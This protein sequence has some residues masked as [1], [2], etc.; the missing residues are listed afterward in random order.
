[1]EPSR[2]RILIMDDEMLVREMLADM[3]DYLGYDAECVTDGEQALRRYREELDGA[4]PFEVVILDL[5]IPGGMGGLEALDGLKQL[6][7]DVRTIVSSGA[8]DS[9]DPQERGFSAA[10][11]KPF[12]MNDLQ[13]A[14]RQLIAGG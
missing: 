8:T 10:I 5:T 6:D 11:A 7:A 1:M 13:Q 3:L 12:K 2:H 14:I 4:T 9:I